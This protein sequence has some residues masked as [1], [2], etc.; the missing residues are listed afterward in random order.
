MYARLSSNLCWVKPVDVAAGQWEKHVIGTGMGDWPHG[1]L[2][3]PLLP[4]RKPALVTAYHSSHSYNQPHFPELF[5]IPDDPRQSP[6]PKKVVAEIPYGEELA[7]Y[8]LDGNGLLDIVAGPWILRNDGNG[9]FKPYR[10]VENL[11]VARLAVMDVN[12]D[13]KPDLVMGEEVLDFQNKTTPL[14]RLVWL[15]NPGDPF[16]GPWK[17]H[18]IDKVWCP[19]SVGV[20]DFDGDGELEIVCGEH[21][22]FHPYRSRCR[23]LMY[24]KADPAGRRWHRHT[25]DDRFEHHDGTKVVDLGLGRPAIISHGW[26]DARYVHLWTP[27]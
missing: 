25:I 15:E 21:E 4:G 11:A 8:D 24:K 18:V 12:G 7:A 2:V 17:M 1:S 27:F 22:P 26:R 10:I 9:G 20:G 5:T 16:S 6:W 13:G 3:A 23:T 19:H 14:S